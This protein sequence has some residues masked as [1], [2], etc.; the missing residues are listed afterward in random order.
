MRNF[1]RYIFTGIGVIILFVSA[2]PAWA[3]VAIPGIPAPMP[4]VGNGNSL[5]ALRV[6]T[7]VS[8]FALGEL[9]GSVVS[10]DGNNET[11]TLFT[12]DYD[13]TL[14]LGHGATAQSGDV[15]V[16]AAVDGTAGF[17]VLRGSASVINTV[18]PTNGFFHA[19]ANVVVEFLDVFTAIDNNLANLNFIIDYAVDGSVNSVPLGSASAKSEVWIFPFGPFP[20]PGANIL[21]NNYR[22]ET[23]AAGSAPF[24]THV[25]DLTSD[26]SVIF[27]PGQY[28]MCGRVELTAAR[29]A[30]SP[31]QFGFQGHSG[32]DFSHTI[33]L[34]ITPGPATPNARFTTISGYNYAPP[35]EPTTWTLLGLGLPALFGI[36]RPR[37]R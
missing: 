26:G 17:G 16:T 3:L 14:H 32:A 12:E 11:E 13:D 30:D 10:T 5:T 24:V 21:G 35:P 33:T 29:V 31:N 15:F 22:L 1:P 28:W 37:R 8:A 19:N 36:S 34:A 20:Q 23:Q 25:G 6:K 2:T 9:G 7:S 27:A 18:G 4:L